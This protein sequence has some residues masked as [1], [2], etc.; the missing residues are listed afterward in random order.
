MLSP[1]TYTSLGF[2]AIQ[3]GSFQVFCAE[4]CGD[5]H[6]SMLA[7]LH[8]LPLDDYE[9]WLAKDPYKGLS[10]SQVGKTVFA[11]K[12]VACHDITSKKKIGP[13]LKNLFNRIRVFD[14]GTQSQ[15]DENYIRQ[16]LLDPNS[17]I[18]KGFP[19]GLMPTFQGQVSEK[20]ILGLIEYI[21]TL[22]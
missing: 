11:G 6:S 8:V 7:K 14:D 19:K 18:V 12:C 20:E 9:S 13:G 16:S 17:Q 5:Q 4:F 10:L 2:K 22:K 21:K 15:A 1:G 3:N